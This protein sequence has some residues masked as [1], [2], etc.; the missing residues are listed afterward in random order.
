MVACYHG[1]AGAVNFLL[2]SAV[3]SRPSLSQISI[4]L[5]GTHSLDNIS[6]PNQSQ[7]STQRSSQSASRVYNDLS[8]DEDSAVELDYTPSQHTSEGWASLYHTART[9]A[10]CSDSLSLG[11]RSP[12]GICLNEECQFYSD[13]YNNAYQRNL[14][15]GSSGK[16]NLMKYF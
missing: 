7:T 13:V 4:C 1:K 6:T 3:P 8:N 12:S 5:D 9:R 10:K 15:Y 16:L 11:D 2:Q 14:Y